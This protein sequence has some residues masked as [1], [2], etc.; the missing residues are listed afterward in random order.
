[1]FEEMVETMTVKVNYVFIFPL[2]DQKSLFPELFRGIVEH[3]IA[4]QGD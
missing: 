1:M 4:K 3:T 2:S